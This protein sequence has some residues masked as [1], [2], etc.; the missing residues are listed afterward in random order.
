M[1]GANDC[2][3]SC[4]ICRKI[5]LFF[6]INVCITLRESIGFLIKTASLFRGK[7]ISTRTAC[8]IIMLQLRITF[9]TNRAAD[10]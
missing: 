4:V 1:S 10:N 8:K 5:Q 9:S 6:N 3:K 7:V 2:H